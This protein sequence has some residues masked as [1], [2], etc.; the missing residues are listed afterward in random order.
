VYTRYNDERSQ[1]A[2]KQRFETLEG[3]LRILQKEIDNL[4]TMKMN[5]SKRLGTT[6]PEE[7]RTK[8]A[9]QLRDLE[10]EY[11][12]LKRI[13]EIEQWD[14]ERFPT[15]KQIVKDASTEGTEGAEKADDGKD[16]QFWT[17][18]EWRNLRGEWEASRHRLKLAQQNLGAAHP[19][20]VALESDVE[21]A[22]E[23]LNTREEQLLALPPD[24]L[25]QTNP[26]EGVSGAMLGREA[27]ERS[28]ERMKRQLE[29]LQD[30][31]DAHLTTMTKAGDI[32]QEIAKYDEDAQFKRDQYELVRARINALQME[33]KVPE[34]I[35]AASYAIKPSRPSS[36]R[37]VILSIMALMGAGVAGCA[38][39]YLRAATDQKITEMDDVRT[40]VNVP[41]L[42]HFPP[43]TPAD[44]VLTDCSPL[45]RECTRMVRTALL[46]RLKNL[47]DRVTLVTSSSSQV[48]KTTVAILLATSLA[49]LG[50]KTL[51]VDADL[52]NPSVASR[53]GMTMGGGLAALLGE[54]A[55][56]ANVIMPS[57]VAKLDILPAGERHMGFDT[58]LLAN[59][60]FSA[61]LKRW[62]KTYDYVV[63]DSPPVL[64]VADAR[65]L[66]GQADG[67]LMVLRSSY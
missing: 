31:I 62:K 16:R 50:K 63:L 45:V 56:D 13:Y 53:L 40:T 25:V 39:A 54:S 19:R 46:E 57:S 44:A 43:L 30:D 42:G 2:G 37:R 22:K 26:G 3:D 48:G 5:S 58:E 59:G 28:L 24:M 11:K 65:I 35:T 4:T 8:L 36:D 67:T 15:P 64:P 17:D 32:A 6:G 34:Q 14:L 66:A 23:R 33:S 61:C 29:L 51:L 20:I 9:T 1:D 49:R 38:A 7:L 47:D 12:S 18:A 60:V 55:R 27:L 52:R 10:S 41:F 21:F